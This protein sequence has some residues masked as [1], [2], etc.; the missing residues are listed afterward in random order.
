MA[1]HCARG[2]CYEQAICEIIP[3]FGGA[4]YIPDFYFI[5]WGYDLRVTRSLYHIR[6][7]SDACLKGLLKAGW[8]NIFPSYLLV[9]R[10]D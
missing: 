8:S 6:F 10:L 2:G 3:V 1:G 5:F 7:Y 9:E 4:I